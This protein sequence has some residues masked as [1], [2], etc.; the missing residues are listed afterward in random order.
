MHNLLR[1]LSNWATVKHT[2]RT[3]CTTTIRSFR[4]RATTANIEDFVLEDADE[5]S[6]G[7]ET[8]TKKGETRRASSGS[9]TTIA[10]HWDTRDAL[11]GIET[12][13]RKTRRAGRVHLR[14]IYVDAV[15]GSMIQQHVSSLRSSSN[16][17]RYRRLVQH[18]D[19]SS[20]DAL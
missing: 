2:R 9:S 18:Q 20:N 10:R 6:S 19:H 8:R 14:A 4:K 17:G 12:R 1:L 13:T 7:T 5:T 15:L 16:L 3:R 11:T